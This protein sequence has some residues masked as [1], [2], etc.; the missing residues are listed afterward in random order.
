MNFTKQSIRYESH[1]PH[2]A[3]KEK[4][5]AVLNINPI[6]VVI[7]KATECNYWHRSANIITHVNK[8]GLSYEANSLKQTKLHFK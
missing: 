3:F 1:F 7:Q 8:A 6:C 5:R 4:N 2:N